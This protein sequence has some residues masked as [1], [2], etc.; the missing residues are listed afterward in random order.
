MITLMQPSNK[1]NDPRPFE[2]VTERFFIVQNLYYVNLEGKQ[3]RW[4]LT[5]DSGLRPAAGRG[6]AKLK[7]G[8]IYSFYIISAII[9]FFNTISPFIL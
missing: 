7:S 3:P 1:Q 5:V 8:F 9:I 6:T 2:C 4:E